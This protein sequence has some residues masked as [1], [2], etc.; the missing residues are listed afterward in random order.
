MAGV[1]SFSID[2][3]ISPATT[4]KQEV[5]KTS[6]FIAGTNAALNGSA[7][8]VAGKEIGLP[9]KLVAGEL[10]QLTIPNE[11]IALSEPTKPGSGRIHQTRNT[12][13]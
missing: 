9:V 10:P 4:G 7:H 6:P 1:S 11:M 8:I 3:N 5:V 2:R 12:N 13:G